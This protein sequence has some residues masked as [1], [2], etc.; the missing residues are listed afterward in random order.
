VFTFT[1]DKQPT[2]VFFDLHNEIVL[3]QAS[4]VVGLVENFA[5][6]QA[7]SLKQNYPN[8]TE[9]LTT[10]TYSLPENS[11]TSL[12]LYDLAGK[13]VM[14]LVNGNQGLGTH[15]ISSDL[16]GLNAGIYLCRLEAGEQSAVVKVS[17]R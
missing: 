15:V 2:N 14:D 11:Q 3:K 1:F 9:G 7:F 13:K 10:F 4:L 8:P 12:A 16:S 6:E 17:I 5:G